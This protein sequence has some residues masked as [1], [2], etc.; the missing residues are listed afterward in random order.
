MCG[1]WEE[2]E[3]QIMTM[4]KNPDIVHDNTRDRLVNKPDHQTSTALGRLLK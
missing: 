3:K 2:T 4:N 1:V